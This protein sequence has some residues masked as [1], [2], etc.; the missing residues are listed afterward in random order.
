MS[1]ASRVRWF[2]RILA[3]V[4]LISDITE[5]DQCPICKSPLGKEH[6]LYCH[7]KG[8]VNN[9]DCQKGE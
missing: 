5:D 6:T 1:K 9:D 7:K 3:I 8:V 2:H 4:G